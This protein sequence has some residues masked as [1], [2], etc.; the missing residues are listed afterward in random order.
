MNYSMWEV[1]QLV[2]ERRSSLVRDAKRESL[3]RQFQAVPRQERGA[4]TDAVQLGEPDQLS[5]L[6]GMPGQDRNGRTIRSG[7]GWLAALLGPWRPR[8]PEAVQR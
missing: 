6:E 7:W 2:T 3:L 1:H 4:W 8:Q 5:R